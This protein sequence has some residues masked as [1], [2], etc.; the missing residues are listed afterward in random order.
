MSQDSLNILDTAKAPVELSAEQLGINIS[1]AKIPSLTVGDTFEFPVSISFSAQDAAL[2][3][4]PISSANTKGITQL[5]MSQESSRTIS[6][7]KETATITFTY[8]LTVQDTGNL[9]VPALRF[10]IPTTTGNS[11]TLHSE[12]VPIRVDSEFNALPFITAAI[13]AICLI[14]AGLWRIKRHSAQ[15]FAVY[16]ASKAK[17]ELLQKMLVL[18]QRVNVADSREWLLELESICKE[19]AAIKFGLNIDAVNLETLAKK[20]LLEGWNDLLEEFAHARYGGGMRDS[21]ENKETWKIA[22]NLMNLQEE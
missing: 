12:S 20:D 13:V 11:I 18:K 16:A 5:G 14:V 3:V 15:K 1:V 17:N 2:L 7:G 10:E 4:L 9:N 21:F 6:N 22:M 8:K 19:F